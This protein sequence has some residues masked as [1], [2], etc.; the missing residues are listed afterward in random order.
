MRFLVG[1]ML[2]GLLVSTISAQEISLRQW[3]NDLGVLESEVLEP[4]KESFKEQPCEPKIDQYLGAF[5]EKIKSIR[6]TVTSI[7]YLLFREIALS[8]GEALGPIDK[9]LSCD[10]IDRWQLVERQ[11]RVQIEYTSNVFSQLDAAGDL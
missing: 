3:T 5:I 4:L 8:T 6:T 2:F 7:S 10:E 9:Y 11:I 1:S